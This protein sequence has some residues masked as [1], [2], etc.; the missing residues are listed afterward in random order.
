MKKQSLFFK[1]KKENLKN[2]I[3]NS[4]PSLHAKDI[5][6]VSNKTI[7]IIGFDHEYKQNFVDNLFQQNKYISDF[8]A[9]S[10]NTLA[11][12]IYII[13]IKPLKKNA[14]LYQAEIKIS[15]KLRSLLKNHGDFDIALFKI[16]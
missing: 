15:T 12:H 13:C 7:C 2:S 5:N 6:Q 4:L 10:N 3:N 11:D 8:I 14:S 16:E 9:A 1:M